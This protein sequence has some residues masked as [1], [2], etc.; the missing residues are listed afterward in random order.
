MAKDKKSSQQQRRPKDVKGPSSSSNAATSMVRRDAE[1]NAFD[2]FR[3]GVGNREA[4]SE[5]TAKGFEGISDPTLRGHFKHLSKKDPTT[6]VKALQ[7][8]TDQLSS[9]PE[10][11]VIAILPEWVVTLRKLVAD[12]DRRVR[13]QAFV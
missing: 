13:E 2:R 7:I 6:R 10:Y 3:L 9:R 11:E 4:Q 8:I 5:G 12:N 1:L